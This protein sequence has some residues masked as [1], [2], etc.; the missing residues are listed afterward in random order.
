MSGS[1][2]VAAPVSSSNRRL[3]IVLCS[4]A[5]FMYWMALYLYAPT[6]PTY[7][8]NKADNLALVGTVLSMYGLWQMLIRFPLGI[9]SDWVGRRKPFIIGGLVL[10]ALGAW[11]M[12]IAQGIPGLL[13]GRAITGLAAG[14]WVPFVVLF[15]SLFPPED[16][17]RAS[18]LL[19]LVGS[20]ARVLA[21]GV[22]GSLNAWGGYSL[23]FYMAAGAAALAM[24]VVFSTR[25]APRPPKKPS[26]GSIGK[27]IARQDVLLPSLL[28]ALMQYLNWAATFSFI[29]ILAKQ[30][31]A[32]DISLSAL[33]SMNMLVITGGNLVATTIVGRLG[34]RRLVYVALV[35]LAAGVGGSAFVPSLLF[36][37]VAQ[38][39]IGL[40]QG[41]GYPVL[42]GMSIRYVDDQERTSAMGLHQAVYAIGMFAG[43]AVSGILADSIGLRPMFG[44]TACVALVVGILATRRLEGED[45]APEGATA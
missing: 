20:V 15:S 10:A 2:A 22:T 34:A 29:P 24:V 12:A 42:M 25:E 37:F 4:I 14:I 8:E 45:K 39:S 17:V 40:A 32:T 1:E 43:P 23:A 11:M 18:T 21:T 41:I 44:V 35:L 33:L 27:L 6:L 31:G 16:A 28:S 30:L 9:V 3:P 7:V 36:V 19:T 26:L 5:V 13:V 38:F